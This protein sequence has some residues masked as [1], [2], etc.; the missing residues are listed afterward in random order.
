MVDLFLVFEGNFTLLPEWL[1]Q[2]TFPM[3]PAVSFV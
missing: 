1:K 2:L 3:A